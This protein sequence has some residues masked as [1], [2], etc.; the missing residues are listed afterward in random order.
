LHEKDYGRL[1]VELDN[2]DDN[3]R[4]GLIKYFDDFPKRIEILT[5]GKVS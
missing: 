4:K 5:K 3:E 2:W 1:K